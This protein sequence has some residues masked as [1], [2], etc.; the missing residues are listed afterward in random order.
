M[1][2]L[3]RMSSLFWFCF[4]LAVLVESLRI[5]IGELRRPQAGFMAYGGALF[6][7]I[8]SLALFLQTFF[9][10]ERDPSVCAFQIPLWRRLA[11]VL[12]ALVLYGVV[13]PKVG[14]LLATFPLMIFLLGTLREMKRRWILV[15]SLAITLLSYI[16]F[17]KC[18]DVQ[19]PVGLF[20]F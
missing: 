6:L 4:A 13:L 15:S 18:L 5:G 16:L 17:A 14:Y 10:K 9:R 11:A 20:G 8:L 2:N 19:L 3:D 12:F 1:K 7:G